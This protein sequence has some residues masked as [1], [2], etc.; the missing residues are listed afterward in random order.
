MGAG[1]HTPSV[2]TCSSLLQVSNRVDCCQCPLCPD[3]HSRRM[4]K[5]ILDLFFP[6]FLGFLNFS[7][8]S[9]AIPFF[10]NINL[11]ILFIYFWLHWVFAVHRLPPVVASGGYSLLRCAGFS[12]RWLLVAEH[13]L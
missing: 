2:C 12:L 13:G 10:L 9:M 5:V 6:E 3:G 11:F 7:P 4:W 1:T 8:T